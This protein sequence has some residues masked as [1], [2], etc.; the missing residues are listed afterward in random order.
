MGGV[1]VLWLLGSRDLSIAARHKRRGFGGW[2]EA[3]SDT[4]PTRPR[5]FLLTALDPQGMLKEADVLLLRAI[6]IQEEALGPEH[7]GLATILLRGANVLKMQV[8]HLPFPE[9]SA[10]KLARGLAG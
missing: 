10:S 7:P 5:T 3:D 6:G 8:T 9:T 4:C 1:Q 2:A